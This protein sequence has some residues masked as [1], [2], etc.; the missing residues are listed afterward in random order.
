MQYVSGRIGQDYNRRK[1]REGAFWAGRYHV[2]LVETG[3]HL[4]RCM[5]Y[6]DM[7][8]VRAGVVDHPEEW[9]C[10]GYHELSGDQRYNYG[11]LDLERLLR[12][13]DFNS[14]ASFRSWYS[15][16][17]E[18]LCCREDRKREAWWTESAAVGSEPW[19][20]GLSNRLPE[21]QRSVDSV[22]AD[23]GTWILT[24][25]RRLKQGFLGILG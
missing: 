7:N 5:F 24:A 9:E 14:V 22:D 20:R 2:T 11:L 25:G 19:I 17:V 10:S 16:T 4:S 8:M 18:E 3:R 12:F 23:S 1:Q 15:K 13:L 6:V 21:R